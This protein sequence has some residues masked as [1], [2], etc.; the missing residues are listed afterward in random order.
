LSPTSAQ[1]DAIAGTNPSKSANAQPTTMRKVLILK[2]AA[3]P[4]TAPTLCY[5]YR[6]E[7]AGKRLCRLIDH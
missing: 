6:I 3:L 4:R 5:R 1:G 7:N 2:P